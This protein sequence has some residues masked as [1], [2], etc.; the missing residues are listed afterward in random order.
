MI[1]HSDKTKVAISTVLAVALFHQFRAGGLLYDALYLRFPAADHLPVC[2]SKLHFRRFSVLGVFDQSARGIYARL[3]Q[4]KK[5]VL[6]LSDVGSFQ[7]RAF[8]YLTHQ[9]LPGVEV[10]DLDGAEGEF[11]P[12]AWPPGIGMLTNELAFVDRRAVVF[13]PQAPVVYPQLAVAEVV[14]GD[15]GGGD[16]AD[17]S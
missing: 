10:V 1:F 14:V 17:C 16:H 9:F 4:V 12:A 2:F 13:L 3:L 8:L 15:V 11:P 5:V 7:L 6:H